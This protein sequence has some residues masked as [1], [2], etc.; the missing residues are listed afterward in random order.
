ME[1]FV[2][3]PRKH[4]RDGQGADEETAAVILRVWSAQSVTSGFHSSIS[5][6]FSTP[7]LL[8]ETLNS[9]DL[10]A[11]FWQQDESGCPA[12]N[13]YEWGEKKKNNTTSNVSGVA[14]LIRD[15]LLLVTFTGFQ[16]VSSAAQHCVLCYWHKK[17]VKLGQKGLKFQTGKCLRMK[18][19]SSEKCYSRK[20]KNIQKRWRRHRRG[21]SADPRSAL[22]LG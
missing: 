11:R 21:A 18:S 16:V 19:V 7:R 5:C 20:I 6:C 9:S 3:H 13:F 15:L 17:N 1:H 2:R 4:L 14:A 8:E 12:W 22:W 10:P